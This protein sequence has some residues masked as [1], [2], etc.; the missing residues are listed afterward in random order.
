[1]SSL[2][3]KTEK[4]QGSKVLVSFV[5]I[6][7]IGSLLA[8]AAYFGSWL[9]LFPVG[10]HE[11]VDKLAYF[12]FLGAM[13]FWFFKLR[14]TEFDFR[15]GPD[16]SVLYWIWFVGF[17][18][19]GLTKNLFL[20]YDLSLFRGLGPALAIVALGVFVVL[21]RLQT[22]SLLDLLRHPLAKVASVVVLFIY[23]PSV[24]QPSWGLSD[25][26]HW[27]WLAND[28][29]AW[30]AGKDLGGDYFAQYSNLGGFPLIP[31]Q[32][33]PQAELESLNLV[34]VATSAYLT[35]L[36][37]GFLALLLAIAHRLLPKGYKGL[38]A[39]LVVP[40]TFMANYESSLGSLGASSTATSIRLLV[41]LAIV[42]LV[43]SAVSTVTPISRLILGLLIGVL[44]W[45]NFDHGLAAT[46]AGLISLAVF[47]KLRTA[48][49]LLAG[50]VVGFV[51]ILT[52]WYLDFS[53][54]S[55][56]VMNMLSHLMTFSGGLAG[57]P[58][59]ILGPSI[60]LYPLLAA[61]SLAA[62]AL[63]R[64]NKEHQKVLFGLF[65]LGLFGA[66]Q[67]A[68]FV[69]V[70][71]VS[72]QMQVALPTLALVGIG[73]VSLFISESSLTS[74]VPKNGP[75]QISTL[76]LQ[77][78]FALIFVSVTLTSLIA[79]PSPLKE[80]IRISPTTVDELLTSP[81]QEELKELRYLASQPAG[82][83]GPK[84]A[85]NVTYGNYFS[86]VL[87]VHSLAK[88]TE[89]NESQ[90]LGFEE[91]DCTYFG[92]YQT[93]IL[94][95]NASTSSEFALACGYTISSETQSFELYKLESK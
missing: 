58:W 24:I 28:L 65:L 10:T 16:N 25:P 53:D 34:P 60:V 85:L 33:F 8:N 69:T 14:T 2:G 11:Q 17:F 40:L 78:A 19:Y 51:A 73:W 62:F 76:A 26:F 68:Y 38:A 32:L 35:I 88:V 9:G 48:L 80:L 95:K 64:R 74:S 49:Q 18:S 27:K 29:L 45:M 31:L 84:P 7:F 90:L 83:G 20:E 30:P 75:K 87:G 6:L 54:P 91:P 70:S 71:S 13:S 52:S 86:L 89:P 41:G 66:F 77:K 72:V 92:A 1:L 4:V 15:F 21:D 61:S 39:I 50:V 93:I 81:W 47:G 43:L 67:M 5:A 63:W 22:S 44:I 59:P 12:L 55:S 57:G 42:L 79:A 46:V 82:E 36:A 23:I 37:L 94:D 3:R 56:S